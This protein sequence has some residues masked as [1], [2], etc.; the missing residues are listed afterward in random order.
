MVLDRA[1]LLRPFIE[2]QD[3]PWAG[4]RQLQG[5]EAQK[6]PQAN[7][8]NDGLRISRFDGLNR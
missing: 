8:R 5:R 7:Y 4:V 1:I 6:V 3:S 2:W